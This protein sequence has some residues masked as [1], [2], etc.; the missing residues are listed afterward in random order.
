MMTSLLLI[1]TVQKNKDEV[2]KKY[3]NECRHMCSIDEKWL[4]KC[5]KSDLLI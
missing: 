2:Y 1:I 5:L 3:K 4:E